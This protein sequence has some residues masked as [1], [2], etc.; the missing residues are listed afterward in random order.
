M[1]ARSEAVKLILNHHY[2]VDKFN[3]IT[4]Y[5][6]SNFPTLNPSIAIAQDFSTEVY[7]HCGLHDQI[8]LSQNTHFL[9]WASLIKQFDLDG[10]PSW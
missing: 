1:N 10:K 9:H 5:T 7:V 2:K 8:K 3:D 6:Y 4:E